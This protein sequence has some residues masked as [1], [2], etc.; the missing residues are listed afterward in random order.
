VVSPRSVRTLRW[1][2][3]PLCVAALVGCGGEPEATGTIT[4]DRSTKARTA[5]TVRRSGANRGRAATSTTVVG[6]GRVGGGV[7]TP[8]KPDDTVTTDKP[9][10]VTPPPVTAP[11]VTQLPITVPPI[12]EPPRPI[13]FYYTDCESARAAGAAPLYYG[14][15][16]YWSALDPDGD[17]IACDT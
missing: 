16:G 12:T 9:T 11:P 17:G 7:A 8:D 13:T 6:S 10:P 14:Y 4:K 15:E 1:L 2:L 3:V 5:T